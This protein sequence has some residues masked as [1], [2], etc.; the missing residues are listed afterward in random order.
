MIWFI[1]VWCRHSQRQISTMVDNKDALYCMVFKCIFDQINAATVCTRYFL[2]YFLYNYRRL[3]LMKTKTLCCD[4]S[5]KS[6]WFDTSFAHL[7]D[8]RC[9]LQS[10]SALALSCVRQWVCVP[11]SHFRFPSLFTALH[12]SCCAALSIAHSAARSQSTQTDT[13]RLT[14]EPECRTGDVYGQTRLN[15]WQHTVKESIRA[16]TGVT[17]NKHKYTR[18]TTKRDPNKV[19]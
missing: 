3:R 12:S 19:M 1:C 8:R 6:F 5:L 9:P 17:K 4:W 2:R 10:V 16:Q 15:W 14:A 13:I 11:V 18:Q 7:S